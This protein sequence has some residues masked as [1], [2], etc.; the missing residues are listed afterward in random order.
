MAGSMTQTMSV[1]IIDPAF[2]VPRAGFQ[3]QWVT[4]P[5]C[6]Y[7]KLQGHFHLPFCEG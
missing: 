6:V 4:T 5:Y 1:W 3:R 2:I 7:L